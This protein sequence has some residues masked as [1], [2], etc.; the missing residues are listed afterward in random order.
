[1]ASAT[2]IRATAVINLP[3]V[4]VAW[5]YGWLS[6]DESRQCSDE[7]GPKKFQILDKA[8]K[9]PASRRDMTAFDRC[10]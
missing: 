1:V 9:L 2:V 6:V 5:K 4:F 3:P 10:F 8:P 7:R